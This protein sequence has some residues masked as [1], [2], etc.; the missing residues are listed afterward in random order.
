LSWNQTAEIESFEKLNE[1]LSSQY[2][3]SHDIVDA[4][5]SVQL[6]ATVEPASLPLLL[7]ASEYLPPSADLDPAGA[8]VEDPV[9]H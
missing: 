2:L 5:T 4:E 6:S 9:V 1:L 7:E 8:S 3:R